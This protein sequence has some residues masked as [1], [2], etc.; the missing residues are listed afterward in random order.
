MPWHLPNNSVQS[1]VQGQDTAVRTVTT[2]LVRRNG[3]RIQAGGRGY[4][5]HKTSKPALWSTKNVQRKLRI[6][7]GGITTVALC[8]PIQSVVE[9]KNTQIYHPAICIDLDGLD[10]DI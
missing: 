5:F 10:R 3:F 6:F 1:N 2:H 7:S 8:L 4:F 9:G